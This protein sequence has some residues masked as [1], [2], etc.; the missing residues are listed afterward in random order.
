MTLRF[1]S[2]MGEVHRVGST[3]P[4]DGQFLRYWAAQ[5]DIGSAE[6]AGMMSN[7]C[8]EDGQGSI[9]TPA[10]TP[11]ATWV[12]GAMILGLGNWDGVFSEDVGIEF[13]L[14]ASSQ[15]KLHLVSAPAANGRPEGQMFSVEVRRGATVLAASQPEFYVRE[16]NA[17]QFKATID[18]TT[19]SFEVRM[20]RRENEKW[21]TTSVGQG[22]QTIL[23]GVSV[24]TADAGVANADNVVLDYS[25]K[26]N[27]VRWD[28][29]FLF[30]DQGSNNN[31][32][33]TSIGD[34]PP[35]VQGV[36]PNADG[37]QNDWDVQGGQG[38]G[39]DTVNDP[40]FNVTDDVGRHVSQTPGDIFLTGFQD[41][42]ETGAPGLESGHPI[43][44][45]ATIL[46]MIFH[47]V[48]GMENS[49]TR[50]LRP[51]Y[52][53]IDD[54]RAEGADQAVNDTSFSG[55]FEVFELN[56]ISAAAW[57][58][59]ESKEMQWGLKVQS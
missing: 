49:G 28:H 6:G 7:S 10:F 31:D 55:F 11:Q 54:V 12:A 8:M 21:S 22:M 23:S 1:A 53:R 37:V 24:N 3:A 27:N 5:T 20:A 32:F 36:V 2:S 48:S 57:T 16:W 26:S 41:P 13:R 18:P 30:D 29:F 34:D 15:L 9:E 44:S 14:G 56:P 45:A 25:V 19:G 51:V 59:Q 43:G 38:T 33:P 40:G 52:R 58:V 17:I 35:L 39:F 4:V 47:H 42:G 46:G 50:T